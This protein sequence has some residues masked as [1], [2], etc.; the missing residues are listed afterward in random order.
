MECICA[1]DCALLILF[2]RSVSTYKFMSVCHYDVCISV[3]MHAKLFLC[4]CSYVLRFGYL[5]VVYL[6]LFG[7]EFVLYVPSV[8][9]HAKSPFVCIFCCCAY[10][11]VSFCE[12]ACLLSI[13][14][15]D[16]CC[17]SFQI[18]LF[19]CRQVPTHYCVFISFVRVYVYLLI[20]FMQFCT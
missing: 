19:E 18:F 11:S 8:W 7:H 12:C 15:L 2:C 14:V 9:I 1:P 20:G 5:V 13:Y 4:V 10:V 3:C 6:F 16:A 17:Q